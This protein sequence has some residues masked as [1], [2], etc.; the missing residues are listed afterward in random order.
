MEGVCGKHK[1]YVDPRELQKSLRSVGRSFDM[2]V[3]VLGFLSSWFSSFLGAQQETEGAFNIYV[4]LHWWEGWNHLWYI[5]PFIHLEDTWA[6]RPFLRPNVNFLSLGF[7]VP[8]VRITLEFVFKHVRHDQHTLS[9]KCSIHSNSHCQTF[10]LCFFFWHNSW[11]NLEGIG[12][13]L[14]QVNRWNSLCEEFIGFSLMAWYYS[15]REIFM[16]YAFPKKSSW[17]RIYS[18]GKE[19]EIEEE[20]ATHSGMYCIYFLFLFPSTF[21]FY[22][23]FLTP[24]WESNYTVGYTHTTWIGKK[25]WEYLK[26]I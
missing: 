25:R 4:Y 16:L 18:R 8:R 22:L 24:R 9:T 6:H 20:R 21:S 19:R 7:C 5:L 14:F 17:R 10:L 11:R 2:G 13:W 26:T 15:D 12:V 1:D 3:C 23:F